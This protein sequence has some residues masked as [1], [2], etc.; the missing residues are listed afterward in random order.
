[1]ALRFLSLLLLS[2]QVIASRRPSNSSFN[3]PVPISSYQLTGPPGNAAP[4]K[5]PPCFNCKLPAFACGQYG[6]CN[7]YDGQCKCPAG[8]GG[9][10]CLVPQCDSL[11]D[12]DQRRLREG[13]SCDCKEGWGGINCNVCQT[14]QACAGFPL[15]GSPIGDDDEVN[16]DDMRCYT[17]GETVFNNHQ[18]CNVTNRKIIDQVGAHRPVQVT[19]SC[20]APT[21]TCAFQFWVE[22]VESFYC[23]LDTCSS[24]T[25]IGYDTNT[26][27]YACDH[28]K[29]SCI[30][31]RFI[32]GEDGSV[33][34][35]DFL[36]EEIRGPAAFSCKSGSGCRFEEAAMND[37][38]SEIFA[39]PYITLDCLGGECLH[40]SQVPG[41]V[42][43]PKPD[44]SKW[45]ALSAAG[46]GLL[47]LITSAI[48]WYAGR[49]SGGEFGQIRLPND[50]QAR[51]MNDHVP[52]T[53]H[54]SDLSYTLGARVL[55]DNISGTIKPGQVCA[56][57]G[58]SGAGKS[59]FLDIL[60]RK[61]KRGQVGGTTY[62][63]GREVRKEEFKA[64]TGFVDQEDT[65]MS[66]LTVY[67]T[68]LYSALL[69]LPREMSLEAK[70]FRT[71]ETMNELGILGIKDSR[72]GASGQRSISGGEKRR[73]S[74][75][76][77]LVTSPSILFLDE[78][79]SGLDAYN[80]FNVVECLV[81]LARDYNRTVIFTIHQPR[82]N[83]VA[84]FDQLILLAS[85]KLVYS[86]EFSKCQAY[87]A[88]IGHPCPPG[89]N[90]A[91][92]LIDMTMHA[93]LD[94]RLNTEDTPTLEPASPSEDLT[95]L[96]DEE[97]GLARHQ[98]P[99]VPLST[100]S[101]GSTSPDDNADD[102][103][104]RTRVPS[105]SSGAQHY[106][107][108]KTSQ[109]LEAVSLSSSSNKNNGSASISPKLA[110]LV[111]AYA[112][113][114]VARGIREEGE[115][116][117]RASANATAGVEPNANGELPDVAVETSLLRGRKRASY[118]TQFRILSGRAFKNLYR[119]PALL[120]AH[121][122]SSIALAL[123][124]GLFFHN[125]TND[126][127]GFQNRLGLFFFT[128]ALFGFSCLSSLGLFANE[129][130]LFIR[131]RANGYY[132]TFTYF[133]SKVLF[134]ILP[135]RVVPPI[136]FGG[137][138]YGLVGLVPTVVSFW[139]FMLILVLFNLTTA[140]VVLFLSI[141]IA[142]TSVAGLAGTLVML[143]NLM[144]TGLLINRE[145]V[146]VAFRWLHTISFFHAAFEALAVNE[147]RYL[148]LTE[149]KY[150]VELDVPAAVILSTFGLHAQSFWWPNTVLLGIFFT[151]LTAA[152]FL[153]L[154]F[155]V[156]EKR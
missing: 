71:L 61:S 138:V 87:F 129:R 3:R 37:L 123:I 86:G 85:G 88:D 101:R 68:V 81:S 43:P 72:I 23:A 149:T 134:D 109:F 5:C 115:A 143:F 93:T 102:T 57:M 80:A 67:E 29:C 117:R 8:W 153:T 110:A 53:L 125:V 22:E 128:L 78:P 132:S 19:F 73:V 49:A 92:F 52:A 65:L 15:A 152:S 70:K 54:F 16:P 133:S 40:L 148:H 74:I 130:I 33:N 32:C 42:R 142:S 146:P 66:T 64:V 35:D 116:L 151:V 60:A 63:N 75:A 25:I 100:R 103:E 120:M 55:L 112:A 105:S 126:I 69:R 131:E 136:M 82:S 79:T 36:Q 113:S 90:I 77:E 150:G 9:I 118:G 84:L 38:I 141:A 34:I 58:A 99:A 111:D 144:F 50:E 2:T 76:C 44:T 98:T 14:N 91:D 21:G 83:I 59:T 127:S 97:R 104:L 1:M 30:P 155:F 137:I 108:R 119:D 135:L 147:L 121:Y 114:G 24:S 18:M 89:F 48:L 27:T 26:T 107:K 31:G 124:C 96:G 122:L 139:K 45:V 11:A 28:M 140:V 13:N 154:H 145:S 41:Y 156:K 106:I 47:V 62:V 56:I 95:N 94:E 20:D 12:G 39:D 6:E 51:L 46:A 17:G 7:D 10:D 4:E